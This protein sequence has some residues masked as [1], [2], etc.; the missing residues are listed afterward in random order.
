MHFKFYGKEVDIESADW[1]AISSIDKTTLRVGTNSIEING[2]NIIINGDVTVN[3]NMN[4]SGNVS[5]GSVSE[6]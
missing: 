1:L 5:A 6:G 4:V 3:G 2:T